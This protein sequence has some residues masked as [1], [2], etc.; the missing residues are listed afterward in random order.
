MDEAVREGQAVYSRR[1]LSIYDWWVLGISNRWIWR[2]PSPHLLGH[3]NQQLSA[4]HLDIGVGT[5]YFLDKCTFSAGQP[6]IVLMDL[7]PNTLAYASQRIARYQPQ[8]VQ[9]NVFEPFPEMPS[10]DSV[11]LNFLLHC[12][13]G[14]MAHKLTLLD[15]LKP[16][17]NPG[18]RLFGSTILQGEVPRSW[19]ARRLMAI[20]NRKGI[21]HNQ[22]DTL[23]D[24]DT[25]LKTRFQNVTIKIRGCVAI[26]S[27]QAP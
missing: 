21:F 23:T 6:R 1:V 20:Y 16:V 8:T 7:N 26:F 11:G 24:L 5:G 12:L 4:N 9:H 14:P 25:G 3:Y 17:L 22:S 18:A 13:P 10:F 15:N 2:C 19:A 27:A